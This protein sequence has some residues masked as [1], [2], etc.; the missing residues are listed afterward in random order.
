MAERS[1]ESAAEEGK[2]SH[3]PEHCEPE[4]VISQLLDGVLNRLGSAVNNIDAV[5][6]RVFDLLLHVAAKTCEIGGD[7]G[8]SH[9]SALSWGVAPNS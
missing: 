3:K 6:G 2:G 9:H 8:N 4:H 7:G 1:S 5:V